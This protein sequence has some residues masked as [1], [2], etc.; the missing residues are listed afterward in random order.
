MSA[1]D[2]AQ[3]GMTCFLAT[4]EIKLPQFNA[5]WSVVGIKARACRVSM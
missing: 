2:E 4:A 3:H 1:A 5:Y